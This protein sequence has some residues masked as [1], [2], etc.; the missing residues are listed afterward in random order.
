MRQVLARWP[1]PN[2]Y[3][4]AARRGGRAFAEAG[5]P[6]PNPAPFNVP[7]GGWLALDGL[8]GYP[9]HL[10][11]TQAPPLM[12]FGLGDPTAMTYAGL[13]VVGTREMST[14]GQVVAQT[15]VRSAP[16]PYPVISGLA[17]GVDACAH[18]AALDAG[19]ATVAVLA[20]GPDIIYPAQNADLAARIIAAGGAV[21][22]E[23]PFGT[24]TESAPHRTPAP[25]PG[26]LMARNRIISGLSGALVLAEG[27][28]RSGA[29]HTVWSMLTIGRTVIVAPPKPH[30]RTLPG[31]QGPLALAADIRRTSDQ[32][33]AMGA[34]RAVA[35][36]WAGRGPLSGAVADDRDELALL[37]R[38]CLALSSASSHHSD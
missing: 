11:E 4:E 12:L 25:L 38:V 35:D 34:P 17:L 9:A 32:L 24:G 22:S 27:A 13:G 33:T 19:I 23:Q 30:A 37:V 15:A 20:T 26:R 16:A 28:G 10:A 36:Q 5:W 29:M 2:D 21:I 8:P 6:D 1:H 7:Q 31:A 3:L 18:E 14:Y